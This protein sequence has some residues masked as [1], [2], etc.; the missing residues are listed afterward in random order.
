[1]ESKGNTV[2]IVWFR[3]DLRLSDNPAL[4]AASRECDHILPV[5]IDDPR[6][7]TLTQVGAASRVWLHQSLHALQQSLRLMCLASRNATTPSLCWC[8]RLACLVVITLGYICTAVSQ[9]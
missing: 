1:M 6:E 9:E 8:E 2:G 3:Q 7:Q 5:F 4:T